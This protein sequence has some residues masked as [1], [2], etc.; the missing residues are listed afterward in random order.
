[1]FQL[2]TFNFQLLSSASSPLFFGTLI[3]ASS[4]LRSFIRTRMAAVTPSTSVLPLHSGAS[5]TI[6]IEPPRCLFELR[7]RDVWPY[8]ELLYFFIW[9]DVKIRYKQTLLRLSWSL[10]HPALTYTIFTIF[11][12][13]L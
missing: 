5:A 7:L 8:R 1:M 2:S 3:R 11:F 4:A 9:R 13:P 10:L 6:R 12:R